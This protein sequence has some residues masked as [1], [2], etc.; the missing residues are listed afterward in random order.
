MHHWD[1]NGRLDGDVPQVIQKVHEEEIGF[2]KAWMAEW[3]ER[4]RWKPHEMK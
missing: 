1:E 3:R 4:G 2:V